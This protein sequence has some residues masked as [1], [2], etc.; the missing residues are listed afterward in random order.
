[1]SAAAAQDTADLPGW[2]E[3]HLARK[4]GDDL[5]V[6]FGTADHGVG[7]NR[8][9][10]VVVRPDGSL[11]QVPR[12]EINF[13]PEDAPA[14]ARARATLVPLG[15]HVHPKGSKPHD[16]P[17]ATDLYVASVRFPRPGRYWFVVEPQGTSIQAA[18]AL[19]VTRRTV[20][21]EVGSK[22]IPS[23]NPTLDGAPAEQITTARPPDT[24]LLR[25]SIADSLDA[26]APFVVA[27][28]TPLFC[29]TR[30]C[31]PTVEVVDRV[32]KRFARA[33]V[34]FIHVEIF[35]DN[36]PQK[37]TN[38]WVEEWRLPTEP[39]IFVVDRK[40]IIRAKFEGSVSV[41]ELV[42]AVREHLL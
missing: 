26:G 18:G 24:E 14:S 10:F 41:D 27:F 2:V 4:D 36:D 8:I 6:V 34:R 31:G 40:G 19:H 23:D 32:R 28:A 3:A 5:V 21:P 1:M 20:S 30:T 15:A 35:E 42:L 22:A 12:A 25:Y 38:K 17:G 9:S 11:V 16:H 39:W 37:G 33:G 29:Q 7:A 13:A